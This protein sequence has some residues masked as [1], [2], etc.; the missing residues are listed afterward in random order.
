MVMMKRDRGHAVRRAALFA[1]DCA[2]KRGVTMKP[3]RATDS[4]HPVTP[5]PAAVE[6]N[7][8]MDIAGRLLGGCLR[9]ETFEPDGADV[10]WRDETTGTLVARG[11]YFED[12]DDSEGRCADNEVVLCHGDSQIIFFGSGADALRGRGQEVLGAEA[13]YG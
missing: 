10:I 13:A 11:S 9:Q 3:G 5:E 8:L 4:R 1:V 12:R 7:V 2:T 6:Y